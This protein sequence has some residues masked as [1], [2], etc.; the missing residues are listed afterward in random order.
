MAKVTATPSA[1]NKFSL[2]YALDKP[3]QWTGKANDRSYYDLKQQRITG[4]WDFKNGDLVDL[5][6]KLQCTKMENSF[7][8]RTDDIPK[9][10]FSDTFES[11]SGNVQNTSVFELGGVHVVTYGFDLSQTRQ[12]AKESTGRRI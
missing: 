9:A 10:Y 11:Y 2:G 3:S 1:D 8:G 12:K 5:K 4:G 7:D 6:L